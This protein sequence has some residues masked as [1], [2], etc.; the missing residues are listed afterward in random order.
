MTVLPF[1][2]VD[3]F[4]E[5]PLGGNPAAV[6]PLEQWLDDS[7]LQAIAAENNLSET[8]FTV[9]SEDPEADYHLRWFTPTTEV[10]LCGHATLASGH[11][12]LN[13]GAVRFR[14][15]SGIL[16]VERD[17]ELL[18]LDLPA[19]TVEPA[20]AAGL[21]DALGL[22]HGEIFR[23]RGGNGALIVL[24]E[25]EA[26][27]R[28]VAPDFPALKAWDSLVIVTASGL[29]QDVASRVFAVYHGIDEDPVTGSAHAALVPFWAG[30]LG[31]Q[32]FGAHQV[33]A[34]G[35]LLKCELRG[36]RVVLGGRCFTVI[37]GSFQ[38]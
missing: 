34:R 31:R 14:T 27:V 37:E 22:E 28:A 11:I 26:A 21:L 23:G 32:S 4:A 3:A 38:L 5:R 15:R 25:S 36:D 10:D 1:F 17:G 33:S 13:Q 20:E 35:G 24:L 12:L 6:M 9:P 7:T 16:R 19:S 18:R 29:E 30:R 8:A 2:Q